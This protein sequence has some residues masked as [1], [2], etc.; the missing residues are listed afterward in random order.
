MKN[1]Y[2]IYLLFVFS[3]MFNLPLANAQ[4]KFKIISVYPEKTSII[5]DKKPCG[6][7][8]TFYEGA[9]IDWE[10]GQ[11]MGVV[12]TK[13][14]RSY[15]F[16]QAAFAEKNVKTVQQYLNHNKISSRGLWTLAQGRKDSERYPGRRIA[17]VIG[18]ANY[19]SP[20][21]NPLKNPVSDASAITKHLLDL[22]FN[23]LTGYDLKVDEL[24]SLILDFYRKANDYDIALFYYA[25][26]GLK[27]EQKDYILPCNLKLESS[28]ELK[29][30][31]FSV[32][33]L[34]QLGADSRA[35]G[36]LLFIDAC[37]NTS[38]PWQ[39]AIKVET[40]Q[41]EP[42][43]NF[44]TMYST[45][46]GRTA[47]DWTEST[48]Q[49]SPFA[50]AFLANVGIPDRPLGETLEAIRKDVIRRTL[51][52]QNP[53]YQNRLLD[54]GEFYFSK[55]AAAK[56]GLLVETTP[57][58]ARVSIDG[59]FTGKTSNCEIPSLS[60]GKHTILL[61]LSG[62]EDIKITVDI[63]ENTTTSIKRAF[64]PL[65]GSIS[66]STVPSGAI[67]YLD[68]EKLKNT[69]NLTVSR[70]S[71]GQHEIQCVKEGY[72]SHTSQVTVRT[73][74]LSSLNITLK[75][76]E[77]KDGTLTI[78]TTPSAASV[79]ID[80]KIAKDAKNPIS[81]SPGRHTIWVSS[82]G[83]KEDVQT[84]SVEADESKKLQVSLEKTIGTIIKENV[85][86]SWDYWQLGG[87]YQ[88]VSHYPIGFGISGGWGILDLGFNLGFGVP[89]SIEGIKSKGYMELENGQLW[90][91][92]CSW[93]FRPAIKYKYVGLGVDLGAVCAKSNPD[94]RF[95]F[96]Y[97]DK[98]GKVFNIDKYANAVYPAD[99]KTGSCFTVSPTILGFIPFP[100]SSCEL[101][102]GVG[103]LICPSVKDL[104]GLTFTVCLR[105]NSEN[106]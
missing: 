94:L 52:K 65:T 31:G 81:L 12:D 41:I 33:E 10:E 71:P 54:Y 80:G 20:T 44:C 8:S 89:T 56:G 30:D 98:D 50:S 7:N 19:Q 2:I 35:K 70:V 90:F 78:S 58:G 38:A 76:L 77:S 28:Y 102:L 96:P 60:A 48:D 68:G 73:G 74:E 61:S 106:W 92:S 5:I 103:Y 72:A 83:Y 32:E 18:N 57:A 88:Y 21:I 27:Y 51:Q 39:R 55:K 16:S 63:K 34:I 11:E 62:Y 23:V 24:R 64:S 91:P 49:Y 36:H 95:S 42:P 46:S 97:T 69:S 66:I 101:Y 37:R 1:S 43:D 105:F 53:S 84:I 40:G 85:S 13:D 6:V 59:T 47:D 4:R 45:G 87:G 82:P 26:H 67:V 17:L 104:N 22:G 99:I 25:G 14:N 3:L 15:Y 93:S 79:K 100:N 29:N 86:E 75:K 9:P